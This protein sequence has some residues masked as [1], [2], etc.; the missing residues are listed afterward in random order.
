MTNRE[1]L[2]SL[3]DKELAKWIFS[4]HP[5]ECCDWQNNTPG[6]WDDDDASC[7]A[8]WERWLKSEHKDENA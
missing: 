2:A 1:W 4:A 6:C 8:A 5:C 7:E 3:S